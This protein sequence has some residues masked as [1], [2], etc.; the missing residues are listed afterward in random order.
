MPIYHDSNYYYT[1]LSVLQFSLLF[2]VDNTVVRHSS[3]SMTLIP[4][5]KNTLHVYSIVICSTL[6]ELI[7]SYLN[8]VMILM[9]NQVFLIHLQV[10]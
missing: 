6:Y 10:V 3:H 7:H 9:E 1:F 2:Q 8:L 4:E 5:N